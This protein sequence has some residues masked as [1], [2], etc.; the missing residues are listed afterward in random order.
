MNIGYDYTSAAAQAQGV[1][2]K[3][4]VIHNQAI[5]VSIIDNIC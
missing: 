4:K 3:V 5:Y 1:I 2:C